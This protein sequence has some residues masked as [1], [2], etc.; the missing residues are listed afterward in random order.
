MH[1]AAPNGFLN[2]STS[3]EK[4]HGESLSKEYI[5]DGFPWVLSMRLEFNKT[6]KKTLIFW[7]VLLNFLD[8]FAIKEDYEG[9]IVNLVLPREFFT[10]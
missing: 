8:Q 7:S 6:T 9:K 1:M 2:G 5:R 10:H 3:I 4:G